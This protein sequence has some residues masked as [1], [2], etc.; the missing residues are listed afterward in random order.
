MKIAISNFKAALPKYSALAIP[1]SHAQTAADCRLESGDIV[2]LLDNSEAALLALTGAEIASIYLWRVNADE[3]WLRFEDQVSVIRSPIADDSYSRIYWSGDSRVSGEVLFSY[4]PAVYT[5]GT[6]YPENYYRLGIPAPGSAPLV[7]VSGTPPDNDSAEARYYVYT[8]VGKLGEEGPPSP[9]SALLDVANDGVTVDISDL[10]VD[11]GASTGREIEYIRIYRTV[12]GSTGSSFL[13]VAQIAVASTTYSD[14]KDAAELGEELPSAMWDPPRTSMQGLILTPHGIAFGFLGKIVC[15]S[16]LYLPY[17]FPRDYEL[18]MSDEVVA[19]GFYDYHV[20]VGTKGRPV[21][22]TG[23]DPAT[24]SM[25]EL[26]AIEACASARSMASMGWCAIYASHNG[27]VMAAQ[28]GATVITGNIFN[29]LQWRELD[30]TSIHAYEYAGLYVFFWDNG[31]S[32]GGYVFDPRRPEDGMRATSQWFKAGHRDILNDALYLIDDNDQ[33]WKWEGGTTSRTA[34]W[35]SKRFRVGNPTAFSCCR[36]RAD[37]YDSVVVRVYADG[38]LLHEQT[39]DSA[40]AF[41]LPRA[42]RFQEW[43]IEIETNERVR[44]I[45]I[46]ESVTE[47]QA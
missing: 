45:G 10:V 17:A 40:R 43:E 23:T 14:T 24:L 33:V 27:L 36:I 18:T 1:E 4:T 20:I 42:G 41:R 11:S 30:P 32:Q 47:L 5:G 12:A 28:S 2:P 29:E 21:M 25:Q 13:F 26:P 46:A 37:G 34:T 35:K 38:A 6:E 16:E 8:Y 15:A 44:S 39:V 9:V 3:Y 19:L 31:T 22:I 7:A